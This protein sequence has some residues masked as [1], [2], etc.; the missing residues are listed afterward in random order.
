[1]SMNGTA[2]E[3]KGTQMNGDVQLAIHNN[4]QQDSVLHLRLKFCKRSHGSGV[5]GG[6]KGRKIRKLEAM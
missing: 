6:E 2:K 1:M 5:S 3:E 4:R